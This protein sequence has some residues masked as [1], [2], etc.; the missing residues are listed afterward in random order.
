[1][2]IAL[3]SL[4]ACITLAGN[5]KGGGNGSFH[6]LCAILN[7]YVLDSHIHP[8]EHACS[9]W[10]KKEQWRIQRGAWGA[11][12]PLLGLDTESILSELLAYST[13]I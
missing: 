2:L 3:T 5:L 9:A 10:K 6:I 13:G 7:G 1:M 4:W 11:I 8:L 12:A